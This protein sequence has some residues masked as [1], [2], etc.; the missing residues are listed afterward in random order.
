M[1][2]YTAGPFKDREY[3]RGV[4]AK[5]QAA[6]FTVK[7]DWLDIEATSDEAVTEEYL[8]K[9]ARLDYQ[10]CEDADVL[11]YCNTG[12]LSEGKA[13]ELGIALA[14]SKPIIILGYGGRKNNVFLNLGQPHFYTVEEVI[15]YLMGTTERRSD[16]FGDLVREMIGQSPKAKV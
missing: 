6:G 15:A 13:T 7:A 11:V 12:T 1:T 10:Q 9:M 8:Q 4:R 3:V 2:I 16:W 5:L 14:R